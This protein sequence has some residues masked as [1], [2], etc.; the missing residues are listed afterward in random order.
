[1]NV[2]SKTTL[3]E[4]A[5]AFKGSGLRSVNVISVG[6]IFCAYGEVG[7]EVIEGTGDSLIDVVTDL[8]AAAIMQKYRT[9]TPEIYDDPD[10]N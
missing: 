6:S 9:T 8:I 1:M 4:L 3:A 2:S 5:L 10:T 7:G